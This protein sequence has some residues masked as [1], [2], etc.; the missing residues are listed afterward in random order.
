M[1][2]S[3]RALCR[4]YVKKG[5]NGKN[6]KDMSYPGSN[7]HKLTGDKKGQYAIKVSGHW[8]VFF[9]FFDGDVYVVDYDDYH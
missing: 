4:G 7:L 8:R 3:R 6:M 1:A 9:E 5:T 2:K